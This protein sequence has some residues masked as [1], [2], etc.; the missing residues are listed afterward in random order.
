MD[1]P[2]FLELR[3]LVSACAALAAVGFASRARAE[4]VVCRVTNEGAAEVPF[5]CS[6]DSCSTTDPCGDEWGAGAECASPFGSESLCRP[7]CGTL[8]GCSS[9][10]DCP[11]I[12]GARGTCTL[13]SVAVTEPAGF[14][15]YASLGIT[16]CLTSSELA[17]HFFLACHTRP[18][19][20]RTSSYFAGDCDADGCPNGEDA[21]PCDNTTATCAVPLPEGA[22]T[23]GGARLDGGVVEPRDAGVRTDAGPRD[24]GSG[25]GD[26]GT[27]VERDANVEDDAGAAQDDAGGTQDDAG[28]TGQDANAS[29]DFDGGPAAPPGVTFGGGGGC[30]CAVPGA[31][32][33]GVAGVLPALLALAAALCRRRRRATRR[34]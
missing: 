9:D 4:A 33:A 14:C 1:L 24:A 32:D 22:C 23:L 18:D 21:A 25:E 16:Y 6:N 29:T 34:P 20:A 5:V 15:T 10:T 31:A 8:F 19:G 27:S 2:R 11:R 7:A 17:A 30:R 26:G 28:L 3:F 13:Q 12:G